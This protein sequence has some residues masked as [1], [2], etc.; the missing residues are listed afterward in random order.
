VAVAPRS[1]RIVGRATLTIVMSIMSI[2][3]PTI[4]AIAAAQRQR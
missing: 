2:S 4:I 3:A 1:L